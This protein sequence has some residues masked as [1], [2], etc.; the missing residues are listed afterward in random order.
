[1]KLHL[2]CGKRN[3]GESW[4]HIDGSDYDHI[5]YHNIEKLNFDKGSVYIIYASHVLEYF[6]RE[7]AVEV[8]TEWKRVLKDGG[9]LRLAVPD[10]KSMAEL[11]VKGL[12]PLQCFLGP[13]YGKWLMKN[14]I[15]YHK[16]VYDFQS[17]SEILISVGFK[18]IQHWDWRKT[19]HSDI[20]DF[21]Q[22]YLPHMDKENGNPMSLNIEAIK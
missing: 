7:E 12:Y 15:I 9:I 17:L 19:D 1:M 10:F 20:D 16:T 11:Y 14:D 5:R 2:G 21:S 3:F 4:V 18:T 8:L 6:D 22:A 13:L